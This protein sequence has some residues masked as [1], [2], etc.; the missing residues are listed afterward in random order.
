MNHD[1]VR[2]RRGAAPAPLVAGAAAVL[3]LAGCVAGAEGIAESPV[4]EFPGGERPDYQLGGP[5][6]PAEDVGIVVRDHREAP[7]QGRYNVCYLNAF[8]VD[9]DG[10][11]D[12]ADALLLLADGAPVI[13][14]DWNEPL[15]DTSD[16]GRR[17]KIADVVGG[18]IDGCAEAGFD[19]VEL[20]NLDSYLRSGGALTAEDNLALAGDLVARAH[21]RGLAAGQKNSAELTKRA[22]S[23]GFD[24][25]V[26]EE[27]QH[28]DECGAFTDAYGASVI[29]IEYADQPRAN[30]AEACSERGDTISIVRRD[31][32][33]LPAG[34]EG[35]V[36]QWC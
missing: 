3:L 24:F 23:L 29:E 17:E 13:D 11:G 30:L 31:R 25:A 21:E 8:Q 5:Y 35:H 4:G 18:W 9:D 19:A 26:T 32:E 10:E 28:Y 34:A 14:P 2:R 33:L 16:A 22:R 20:D 15:L 12:W 27:C 7:E 6:P 36:A 1:R